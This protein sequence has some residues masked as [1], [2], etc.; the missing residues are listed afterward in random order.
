M[1][2]EKRFADFL[3]KKIAMPIARSEEINDVYVYGSRV[4]W[5]M[6]E[7]CEWQTVSAWENN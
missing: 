3:R 6:T 2:F 4:P 1:N 7:S 5:P